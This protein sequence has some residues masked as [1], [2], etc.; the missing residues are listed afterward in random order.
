MTNVILYKYPK[1]K[2]RRIKHAQ[3]VN[4]AIKNYRPRVNDRVKVT[5]K[6]YKNQQID[7]Q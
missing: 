7:T 4:F 3:R 5:I 2:I 6:N 1:I